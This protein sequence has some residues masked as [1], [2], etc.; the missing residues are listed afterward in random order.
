MPPETLGPFALADRPAGAGW[1]WPVYRHGSGPPV[2]LIHELNGLT[3]PVL[4]YAERLAAEG[5][6]VWLPVLFGAVPSETRLDQ[7]KAAWA[8][9]VSRE[10]NTLRT[11]R[12]STV[13]TP[14]RALARHAVD[15]AAGGGRGAGVVGMCFSG[16]FAIAMAADDAVLAGVAAQPAV[17]FPLTPWCARDLGMS[18]G[19]VSAVRDR[20]ESGDTALY[21]T[22]FTADWISR[23]SRVREIAR[24]LGTANVTVDELPSG[25]GNAYGFGRHEHSVLSA[26]PA[27]PK[28]RPG[29]AAQA[30]LA[31][32]ARD[33][34][35]FLHERLDPRS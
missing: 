18:P 5:F 13:V 1:T 19:D 28:Y 35:A 30:R 34:A 12:T 14:L 25:P 6:T 16:G 8:L 33:V 3:P 27:N 29:S 2:V 15:Q 4:A 20:L 24:R 23:E 10:I 31:E 7:A 21:V 26:A 32:A 17:P 22:R 9:C 11:G